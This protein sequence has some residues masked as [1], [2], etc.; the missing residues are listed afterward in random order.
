MIK[1]GSF[2]RNKRKA[3]SSI[4]GNQDNLKKAERESSQQTSEPAPDQGTFD[5]YV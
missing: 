3:S 1:N 5:F 4:N 2:I